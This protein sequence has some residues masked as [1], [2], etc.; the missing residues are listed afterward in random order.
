MPRELIEPMTTEAE[1]APVMKKMEVR[2]I[3][4][5]ASPKV[6]TWGVPSLMNMA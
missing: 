3:A 2:I 6:M 5:T 4:S 1:S